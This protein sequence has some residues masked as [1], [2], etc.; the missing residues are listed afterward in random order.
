MCLKFVS[1]LKCIGSDLAG[2]GLIPSDAPTVHFMQQS[3]I[4]RRCQSVHNGLLTSEFRKRVRSHWR[5]TS[6]KRP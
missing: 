1:Y 4:Q 3:T 6:P 5:V 2:E